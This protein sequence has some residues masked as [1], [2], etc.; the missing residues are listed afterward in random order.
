MQRYETGTL[1]RYGCALEI[2][3]LPSR[4]IFDDHEESEESSSN[5]IIP[6]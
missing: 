1:P 5:F 4:Q 3:Q 6:L 2:W